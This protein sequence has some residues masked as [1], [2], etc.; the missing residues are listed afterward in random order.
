MVLLFATF[1]VATFVWAT[2]YY[3]QRL[4]E[5]QDAF[6]W[7]R[8]WVIR[9]IIVPALVWMFFNLGL[10]RGLP[11]LVPELDLARSRA[12]WFDAYL[13]ISADGLLIVGAFWTIATMAIVLAKIANMA[14]DRREFFAIV[15][16]W[17]FFGA[18]FECL[19]IHFV[20]WGSGIFCAV[21]WPFVLTYATVNLAETTT[22]V[23]IYSRA[24]ARMQLGKYEDAE[25]EVLRELEKDESDF[26]GWLILA[27]LYANHFND[28]AAAD[29]TIHEIC[30]EPGVTVSQ[31]SVALH[32]LADWYLKVGKDPAAARRVLEEVCRRLPGTHLDRM[33]RLR[34]NQLP[35]TKEA[36]QK[37]VRIIHVPHVEASFEA[38]TPSSPAP[39][40]EESAARAN[41]LVEKLKADPNDVRSRAELAR[42]FAEHLDKLD[43]AL[44]QME[45]LLAMPGI[46]PRQSAEWLNLMAAWL[47]RF[48]RDELAAQALLE[49]LIR[50]YPETIDAL[51]AQRRLSFMRQEVKV[52]RLKRWAE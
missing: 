48:R 47:V 41:A 28:L 1:M 16:I 19:I 29:R 25:V 30:Q 18:F 46:P 24:V 44:E 17:T 50:D 6:A 13:S 7:F 2:L 51:A 3:W 36:L 32:R 21:V 9:G 15:G 49:R 14:K 35:R 4:D 31:I 22:P 34:I 5:S 52:R 11:S 10:F 27:E 42:I 8:A 43:L 39:S 33:A 23:P 45:L 40:R 26:Q 20:G 38:P 12:A 37:N